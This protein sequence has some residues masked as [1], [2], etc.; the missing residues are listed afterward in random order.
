LGVDG[1]PVGIGLG[2]EDLYCPVLNSY[3]PDDCAVPWPN[4]ATVYPLSKPRRGM[5]IR[6]EVVQLTVRPKDEAL[7]GRTKPGRI[8]TCL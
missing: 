1:T 7:L 6:N 5:V 4:G 3:V 8:V 2:I